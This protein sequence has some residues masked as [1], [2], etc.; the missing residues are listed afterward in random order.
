MYTLTNQQNADAVLFD[1]LGTIQNFSDSTYTYL[2]H[3]GEQEVLNPFQRIDFMSINEPIPC[4][5]FE[6]FGI[7][8]LILNAFPGRSAI[9]DHFRVDHDKKNIISRNWNSIKNDVIIEE[10]K[11]LFRGCDII[12]FADW[13]SVYHAS[14]FWDGL[15]SDVIRPLKKKDF[16]FIFYLGNPTKKSVFETDEI[17]DIMGEYSSCGKVTLV[18]DENEADKLFQHTQRL[19]SQFDSY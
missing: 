9:S 17:L 3:I 4:E 6:R 14:D 1:L 13:A 10:L 5:F 7:R 8:R 18:L 15:L 2:Y 19:E 16:Q 12:Q 11:T